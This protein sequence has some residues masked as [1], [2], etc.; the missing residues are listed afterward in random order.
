ML[1]LPHF[2]SACVALF[3]LSWLM[4][5]FPLLSWLAVVNMLVLYGTLSSTFYTGDKLVKGT[6][7][8]L[9]NK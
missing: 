1:P 3:D 2:A 9:D 4:P 5:A 8:V 6:T 7:A